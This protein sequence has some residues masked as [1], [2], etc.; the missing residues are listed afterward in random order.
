[1]YRIDYRLKGWTEAETRT[2]MQVTNYEYQA[3]DI[4]DEY[5]K[6]YNATCL[7][8]YDKWG[9]FEVVEDIKEI[10]YLLI[11]ALD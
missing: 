4:L 5:G 2:L 6:G 7:Y 8:L 1:M 3:T 10:T 11:T 9:L